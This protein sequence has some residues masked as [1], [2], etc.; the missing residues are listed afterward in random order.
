MQK[1]IF[2]SPFLAGEELICWILSQLTGLAPSRLDSWKLVTE[3]SDSY[4]FTEGQFIAGH[5][6]PAGVVAARLSAEGAQPIFL[7]RNIF[8]LLIDQYRYFSRKISGFDHRDF[9]DLSANEGIALLIAG[10]IP[11][12]F[13]PT[14][15]GIWSRQMQEMLHFSTRYPSCVLSYEKLLYDPAGQIKRLADFLGV[16][17]TTELFDELVIGLSRE[18]EA[19]TG[20][21]LDPTAEYRYS[22]SCKFMGI[23]SGF[24][25]SL[26]KNMLETQAPDLGSLSTMLGFPEVTAESPDLLRLRLERIFVST[27]FKSGTKLLEHIVAKLTGLAVN[28]PGMEAGFDYESV[29]PITFESGTFFIWHNVPSGTVKARIRAE[30]ARPIFLIRNIYDLL[31]SQYFHFANDVDAAIGHSTNTTEYFAKIGRDEGISLVLCGTT[32]EHFNWHGFGYYLRH[33]QEFLKFSKEYPCHVISYDRLVLEKSR[34]IERLA[35]FLGIEVSPKT[36]DDM[37]ESSGLE[38]MREARAA[39]VGSG[40]HFRKGTPGD[41]VNILKPQHYHMINHLKLTYAPELDALCEELGFG[42]IT[43]A[44]P[45][46]TEITNQ[47][48]PINPKSSSE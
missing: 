31:V 7:V 1:I 26:I 11:A 25:F 36:L 3:L 39:S 48:S 45:A 8:D 44:L 28:T 46:I 13:S 24:H 2:S 15:L 17:L 30:N 4:W 38:A 42:D 47:V 27:V 14:D 21:S 32:S 20:G 29:D 41:H 19:K 22:L 37:L 23:L 9:A 18:I 12:K 40:K 43:A 16:E 10:G 34:E 35:D 33:I 6:T 5:F